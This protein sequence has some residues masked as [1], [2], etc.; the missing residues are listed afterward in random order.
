MNE[1]EK[2]VKALDA[3]HKNELT[4]Q[5]RYIAEALKPYHDDFVGTKDEPMDTMLG[6]I[7]REHLKNVFYQLEKLGVNF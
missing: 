6:E 7:Y 2:I 3:L 1:A 5:L 4:A